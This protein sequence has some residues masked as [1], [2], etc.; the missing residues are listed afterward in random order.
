MQ[1]LL[2]NYKTIAFLSGILTVIAA[3]TYI[4]FLL[5]W[6]LFCAFIYG[7]T[8]EVAKTMFLK[9]G[10]FWVGDF[11]LFFFLDDYRC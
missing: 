1:K 8:N 6:G 9:P 5:G 7:N 10:L 2:N 11:Y 4:N 3:V